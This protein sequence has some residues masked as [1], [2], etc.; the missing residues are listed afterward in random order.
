[1]LIANTN[2]ASRNGIGDCG[3]PEALFIKTSQRLLEQCGQLWAISHRFAG[4]LAMVPGFD[5]AAM[6]ATLADGHVAFM[7]V[8]DPLIAV[9]ELASRLFHF[10]HVQ[11]NP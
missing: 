8:I 11:F 3:V 6:P 5:L 1:M 7:Q 9:V 10:A 4:R 2:A